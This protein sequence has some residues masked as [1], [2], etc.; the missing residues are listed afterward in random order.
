[1]T[2]TPEE[3]HRLAIEAR[4]SFRQALREWRDNPDALRGQQ[5]L[6]ELL[7]RDQ[8]ARENRDAA[9]ALINELPEPRPELSAR[10]ADL[11]TVLTDR[12]A[13]VERLRSRERDQ[14]LALFA[15]QRGRFMLK[16]TGVIGMLCVALAML[17]LL[18]LDLGY[19]ELLAGLGV[20]TLAL[21]GGWLRLRSSPG[22]DIN[23]RFVGSVAATTAALTVH[24]ASAMLTGMPF[25]HGFPLMMLIISCCCGV[26]ALTLHRGFGLSA[27]VYLAAFVA[28][29]V[30]P[31]QGFLWFSS[32]HV[33]GF[34]SM[35]AVWLRTAGA[36][37]R[38]NVRAPTISRRGAD[39]EPS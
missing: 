37:E 13:R 4:F 6:L 30:W 21:F 10:L 3:I 26:A 16:M 9:A 34:G 33:L 39:N 27:A 38:V 31:H 36:R 22:N 15:R 18:R 24:L 20:L 29:K 1:M 14:D 5:R 19:P 7:T 17:P 35:A 12:K 28:M 25:E 11:D 2:S 32:G 8:L 23:R